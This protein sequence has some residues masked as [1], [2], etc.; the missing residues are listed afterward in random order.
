M[1]VGAVKGAWGTVGFSVLAP[2]ASPH[3]RCPS[4]LPPERLALPSPSLLSLSLT[5]ND[6]NYVVHEKQKWCLIL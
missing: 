6:G 3:P 1:L 2:P 5:L 4:S